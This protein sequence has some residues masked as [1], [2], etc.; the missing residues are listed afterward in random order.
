MTPNAVYCNL[1]GANTLATTL[2]EVGK[3]GL[4]QETEY[5]WEGAVKLTV[6]EAPKLVRES[7]FEGKWRTGARNLESEYIRRG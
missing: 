1:Y 2:K 6:T 4:V 3:I 5:P 7:N